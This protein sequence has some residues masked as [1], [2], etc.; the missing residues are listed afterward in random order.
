MMDIYDWI[1]VE[2]PDEGG[3]WSDGNMDDFMACAKI[4]KDKGV[5]DTTI[6]EVFSKL[7]SALS[8]E[9]GN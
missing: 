6:K 5:D 1:E 7:Y 4:L 9:F 2:L 8:D 3:R